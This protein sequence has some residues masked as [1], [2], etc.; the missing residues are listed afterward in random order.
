MTVEDAKTTCTSVYSMKISGLVILENV[1]ITSVKSNCES[2]KAFIPEGE[3]GIS[4]EGEFLP[5]KDIVVSFETALNDKVEVLHLLESKED[6]V[7]SLL[8]FYGPEDNFQ[9]P[10]TTNY[11][12]CIFVDSS[13]SMSSNGK[14]K[15]AKDAATMCIRSLDEGKKY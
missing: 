4:V 15:K 13:G 9:I 14:M 11:Q 12:F 7:A 10:D 8:T 6:S 5:D 3:T 1:K 2:L